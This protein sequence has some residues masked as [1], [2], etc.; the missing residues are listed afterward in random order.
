MQRVVHTIRQIARHEVEQRMAVGLGVV[1]SVHGANGQN[2]YACTI[3]MRDTGL[4]LPKVPIATNLI[5]TV[6]LPR[7]NDLVVVL[8]ANH[9][10]HAPVVVGRLYSDEVGP[11]RHG[12]GELVMSLPGEETAPEKVLEIRVKTPGDGSREVTVTLKGSSVS[13]ECR[14]GDSS[15]EMKVQDVTL[16]LTQTGAS[17]GTLELKAGQASV[18]LKQG[19]ELTLETSGTLKLKAGAVEIDADTSVQVNGTTIALN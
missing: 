14:I 1:K 2:D 11:P 15:V 13:V 12:P 7:E 18:T 4:V 19:G 9:D 17:D 8:F 3:E 6:A 10:L 5:G 16:A